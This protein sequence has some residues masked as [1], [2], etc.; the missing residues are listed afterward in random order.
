MMSKAW[1]G[2]QYLLLYWIYLRKLTKV[3]MGYNNVAR[4]TDGLCDW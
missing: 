2:E 3:E 1:I 4:I